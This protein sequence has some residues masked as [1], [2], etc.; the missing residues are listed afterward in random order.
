MLGHP[1]REP[2]TDPGTQEVERDALVGPDL[3]GRDDRRHV[4]VP[5][6]EVDATV[7]V[8]DDRAG[9]VRHCLS[10]GVH[11]WLAAHPRRGPL[12]CLQLRDPALGGVPGLPHLRLRRGELD[13]LPIELVAVQDEPRHRDAEAQRQQAEDAELE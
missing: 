4:V 8:V 13:S 12:D 6:D 2:R 1:A 7:V 10:D 5:L 9:L 3:A 11:G